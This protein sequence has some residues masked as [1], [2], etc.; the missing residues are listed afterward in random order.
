MILD[1]TGG[2]L[3]L[4]QLLLDAGKLRRSIRSYIGL[5]HAVAHAA[6]L[7]GAGCDGAWRSHILGDPVKLGLGL[8]TIVFDLIFV[9][10]H[11]VLYRRPRD[12]SAD[13]HVER[14]P[15]REQKALL[16]SG[17]ASPGGGRSDSD[18]DRGRPIP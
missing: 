12:A 3:S 6:L 8:L 13:E 10:Q 9:V 16:A 15:E 11:Y 17:G 1:L 14:R 5:W 4:T 18:S 7:H 2:T